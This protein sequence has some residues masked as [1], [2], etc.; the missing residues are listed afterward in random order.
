MATGAKGERKRE[1][2]LSKA[3]EL[4]I[5]QGY[6]ATTMEDLVT[7]SGVSKGSIYYHF[8][9]KEELFLQLLEKHSHEWWV[10]WKE[11]EPAYTSFIERIY[12]VAAYYVED[13][14]NPL[15]K[16]AEE[17]S[18]GQKD[19]AML[20]RLLRTTLAPRQ[21]YEEILQ[22]GAAEGRLRDIPVPEL[23]LL[24]AAVLDGLTITYYEQDGENIEQ[25]YRLAVDC[26]LHG[27]LQES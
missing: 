19:Q 18:M 9:S 24:F 21:I 20:E 7:Y 10:A 6:G 23:A 2:I 26:F 17:F 15:I 13:F 11:R 8:D 16:V 5:Q 4:F 25:I 1:L 12:G 3:K 14:Y 22:G 27:V